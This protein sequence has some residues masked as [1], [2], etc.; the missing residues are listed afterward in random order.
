MRDIFASCCGSKSMLRALAEAQESA[1]PVVRLR[2]V[3]GERFIVAEK[4]LMATGNKE[5][6]VVVVST[7][8]KLRRGL[9]RER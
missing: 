8:R 1:V 2:S 3:S 7:M 5:Y 4:G 9:E 6:A